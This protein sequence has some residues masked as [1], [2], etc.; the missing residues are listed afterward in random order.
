MK[1]R[2]RWVIGLILCVVP[3][4]QVHL[5]FYV[6]NVQIAQLYTIGLF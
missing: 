5:H 2:M 6:E 3:P 1:D 4:I